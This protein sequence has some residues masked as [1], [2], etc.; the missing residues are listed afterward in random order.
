MVPAGTAAAAKSIPRAA[1][2]TLLPLI[3]A[4]Y[5]MV[6]G[7][8]FGL[9]DIVSK[10]GYTGTILI[11][12]VTPLIWALPTALMVAELASAL[13]E[14][15]GFYVWAFRSMGP[16]WGFQEAWLSLVGSIFDMAIYPTLFV[17][18]L[19]HF[20]PSLTAGGRGIAIGVALI[21]ICAAWNVAGAK[22]VGGSS[23][24]MTVLLLAPFAVLAAYAGFHREAVPAH[25]VPLHNVDILGG[26][27]VAMWNY[28]GWRWRA[29]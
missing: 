1:R 7:G 10:A 6:S 5:L 17:G 2:V 16:F 3:A 15:G 12:L 20:A 8:P 19:G 24:V 23:F 13:P 11:L 26:I 14:D 18:Y 22:T 4:V 29:P 21:A 25:A 27:L 9:E 28:M